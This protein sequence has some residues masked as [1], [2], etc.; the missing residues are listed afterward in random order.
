MTIRNADRTVFIGGVGGGKG[1]E[2]LPLTN[3]RKAQEVLSGQT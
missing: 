3:H 2:S 1:S